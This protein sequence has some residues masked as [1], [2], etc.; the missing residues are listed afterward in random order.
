MFSNELTPA[1]S[2]PCS[3]PSNSFSRF[4]VA[5]EVLK[6]TYAG[7]DSSIGCGKLFL[8]YLTAVAAPEIPLAFGISIL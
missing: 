7:I 3:Y 5:S 8:E 6:S 4:N 2:C 1:G